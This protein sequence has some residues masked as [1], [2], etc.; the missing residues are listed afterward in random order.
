M[1]ILVVEDEKSLAGILKEML[2]NEG[3][4]ADAVYNGEDGLELART[5]NYE[6][7]ILDVMLPLMDGIE[8]LRNIRREHI[9]SAVLM[10]TAKSEIDDRVN[11][12]DNGA[13]DYMTKPFN[14][15]ELLARVRSM[16]RRY[17]REFNDTMPGFGDL[18]IDRAQQELSVKERHI[19]LSRK[20]FD[21]LEMLVLN[22]GKVVSKDMI[23]SKIWGYD[24][25]VEYNSIEVYISFL[26][27]KLHAAGSCVCISTSRGR[28]YILEEI[29]DGQCP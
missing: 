15:A 11:G 27:K 6:V 16:S 18:E 22:S 12:L 10:L 23:I 2:Q 3:Y 19:K 20:E 28:G 14:T 5:G 1:R 8:V 25:D 24:S 29:T 17:E 13:D 4:E 7:I 26:R 21:L 9:S